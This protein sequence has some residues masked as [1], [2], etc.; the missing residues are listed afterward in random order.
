MKLT[1]LLLVLLI[2]GMA[3]SLLA[4]AK[5]YVLLEH[6]TNSQCSIC[7]SRNPAFFNLISKYEGDVHHLAIHPSVPYPSCVFHQGNPADNNARK[8]YYGVFGTPNVYMLGVKTSSGATLLAEADLQAQLG[9]TSPL[10]LLVEETGG[11]NRDVTVTVN[12]LGTP[13][14]GDLRLFVAVVEKEINQTTG[15]G[16]SVHHNVLRDFITA[17]TGDAFTP[18]ASGSGT[19]ATFSYSLDNSWN[20]DE[21][22]VMAFIQEWNSKEVINSGSSLDPPVTSTWAPGKELLSLELFPNPADRQVQLRLA[23]KSGNARLVLFNALGQP[24]LSENNLSPAYDLN[25]S[26]LE[27][28]WYIVQVETDKGVVRRKLLKK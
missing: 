22:Y 27:N 20:A 13:P 6:F 1:K 21:I 3:G 9:Q 2:A 5:K 25:L 14:S 15:N 18:A 23:E 26:G 19:T 4:Q 12:S 7:A 17:N 8:D 28:G 11:A 16:E 24:V 10:Q